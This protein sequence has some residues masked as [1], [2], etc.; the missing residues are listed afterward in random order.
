VALNPDFKDL[1][2]ALNAAGARYLLVGG[3]AVAFHA[4]PRFTKD[5]DV[6][7]EPSSA[8]AVRV[9]QALRTFGAP[10]QDLTISDLENPDRPVGADPEQAGVRPAAG[11]SGPGDPRTTLRQTDAAAQGRGPA[12]SISEKC[13]RGPYHEN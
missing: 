4:E 5:L 10:V 6:W 1:F 12:H 3:Y 7:V 2:A 8:N 13:D 11:P 9:H